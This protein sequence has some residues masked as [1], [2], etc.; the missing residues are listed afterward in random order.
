MIFVVLIFNGL[1]TQLFSFL[2]DLSAQLPGVD[3]CRFGDLLFLVLLLI[4]A[5][6]DMGSVNF[7]GS[8]SDHCRSACW[9]ISPLESC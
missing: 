7:V 9:M 3:F 4:R 8:H 2:V 1:L 5:G 6:L